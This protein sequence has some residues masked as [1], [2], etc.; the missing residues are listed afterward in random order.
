MADTLLEHSSRVE[1]FVGN[2]R[3]KHSHA[4]FVEHAQD[5]LALPELA[6][7]PP[8]ACF[9]G[10]RQLEQRQVPD[11]ALI[12]GHLALA[13]PLPQAILEEAVGELLAPERTVA[14]AGLGH[15][16]VQVEQSDQAR[17]GAAP[18]GHR[19]EGTAVTC[20]AGQQMLAVLPDTFD[21]DQRRLGVERAENFQAHFL[22]IDETVAPGF[23]VGM[24]P[25]AS[26]A[27]GLE[28]AS[29][30]L[31]HSRLFRPAFLVR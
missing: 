5:G 20:Q 12:V 2:N 30:D 16:G 21:D 9:V 13:K 18:V 25:D 4:A 10:R 22:R 3:V 15:G 14:D 31:F 19:E 7:E 24:G 17:P 23:V 11:M 26:P 27:F 28:S 29:H 6:R 8:A 1:Q